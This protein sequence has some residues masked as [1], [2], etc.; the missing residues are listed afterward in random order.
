LAEAGLSYA[1]A[2]V[3]ACPRVSLKAN[4][5]PVELR[6]TNSRLMLVP[7]VALAAI[8]LGLAVTLAA[9]KTYEERRRLD[10]LQAEI[11]RYAPQAAKAAEMDKS[12]QSARDRARQLD[13]FHGQTRADMNVLLE[14][15]R[16]IEPPAWVNS[17][18]M[19]RSTVTI[20]GQCEQAAPLLKLLDSSPYFRDSE[21][22]GQ[23]GKADKNQVFRIRMVREGTGE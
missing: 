7:T 19:D 15:T 10:L 3:S 16:L 4:L 6:S 22:V 2:L 13:L 1:T 17:L 21:F 20:G 11:A 8:L 14:I 9:Q 12:A 23:I 5:L 18:E